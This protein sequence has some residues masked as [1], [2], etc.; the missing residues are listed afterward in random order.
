MVKKFLFCLVLFLGSHRIQATED[1]IYLQD[2]ISIC[3]DPASYVSC[4]F[5]S[6]N[7]SEIK[8]EGNPNLIIKKLKD[9]FRKRKKLISACLAFPLPFG[10]IGAHRI[11][12]GSEPYVPLIYIVTIGGALGILPLIDFVA[13]LVNKDVEKFEH[14]QKVFMWVK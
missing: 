7:V 9:K 12:L 14:N 5:N 8:S 6:E 11:Y 3:A 4:E 1:I 2:S 13:I 10:I